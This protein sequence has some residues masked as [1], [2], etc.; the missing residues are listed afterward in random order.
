MRKSII[1]LFII[2]SM[3]LSACSLIEKANNSLDYVNQATAFINKLTQFA[4]KAPQLMTDAATNPQAKQELQDSLTG[5]VKD[6]E[7]F[8]QLP[9]PAFAKELHQQL[10]EQNQSLLQQINQVVQNGHLALDK[11]QNSQILTTINEIAGLINR[12]KSLGL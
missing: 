4:E 6:I 3:M 5:L 7:Q 11:L 9:A 2:S 10:I 12:I 1:L 8:N